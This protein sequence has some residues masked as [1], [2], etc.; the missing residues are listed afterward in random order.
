MQNL[1]HLISQAMAFFNG[2]SRHADAL[3]ASPYLLWAVGFV[4]LI[5]IV[6]RLLGLVSL[7][8]LGYAWYNGH[9]SKVEDFIRSVVG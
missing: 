8:A 9:W 4:L 7:G 5:S 1:D 3:L 2:W 6:G